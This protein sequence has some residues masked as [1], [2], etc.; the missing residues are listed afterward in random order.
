M[1]EIYKYRLSEAWIKLF[2]CITNTLFHGTA[3]RQNGNCTFWGKQRWVINL[4]VQPVSEFMEQI[5]WQMRL[6]GKS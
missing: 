3:F 6:C 5:N 4:T 1:N 2:S